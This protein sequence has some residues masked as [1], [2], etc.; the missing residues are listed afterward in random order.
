MPIN[1]TCPERVHS[2][3]T[4]VSSVCDAV[5]VEKCPVTNTTRL[6]ERWHRSTK[7]SWRNGNVFCTSMNPCHS[8][9]VSLPFV[10]CAGRLC[11]SPLCDGRPSR[12]EIRTVWETGAVTWNG[13]DLFISGVDTFTG[14]FCSDP[15]QPL[16]CV[17][18]VC[19]CQRSLCERHVFIPGSAEL[20]PR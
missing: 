17:E 13:R 14:W 18:G 4:C 9:E 10:P 2:H 1:S 6:K 16:S 8:R 12:R 3:F 7:P 15:D 11:V 20:N 19:Q 5:E